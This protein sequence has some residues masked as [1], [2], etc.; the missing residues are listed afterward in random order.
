MLSVYNQCNVTLSI[1]IYLCV[2]RCLH[3]RSRTGTRLCRSSTAAG[4]NSYRYDSYWYEN[5]YQCHV[6]KNKATI[7]RNQVEVVAV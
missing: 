3:V 1:Y 5:S 2:M 7:Y 6:N 4:V